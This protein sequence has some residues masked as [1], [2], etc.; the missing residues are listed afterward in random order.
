MNGKVPDKIRL[1]HMIECIEKIEKAVNGHSFDSFF[2]DEVLRTA[3]VKWLET[4]GEA[5]RYISDETKSREDELEW[6]KMTGMRNITI[7][8]YFDVDYEAIWRA[9]LVLGEVKAKLTSL[10]L[11]LD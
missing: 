3:V 5:A 6:K 1:M 2:D 9:V 10:N 11:G 7:H 4:I 8:K